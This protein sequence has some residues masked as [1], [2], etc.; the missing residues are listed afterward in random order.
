MRRMISTAIHNACRLA[1]R[2]G[3]GLRLP[4]A[5]IRQSDLIKTREFAAAKVRESLDETA[6][7]MNELNRLDAAIDAAAEDLERI[8]Q[9]RQGLS[10]PSP[11]FPIG[12]L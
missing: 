8:H 12:D 3:L 10:V 4:A 5:R 6:Y 9:K 7:W 1:L 11:T 2:F